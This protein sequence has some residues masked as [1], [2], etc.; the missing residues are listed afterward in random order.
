M[1]SAVYPP[2]L[3]VGELD[4]T[5][6]AVVIHAFAQVD[7]LGDHCPLLAHSCLSCKCN[8]AISF[9]HATSHASLAL[10]SLNL[11]YLDTPAEDQCLQYW[12]TMGLIIWHLKVGMMQSCFI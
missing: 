4:Y 3:S 1:A 8:L 6:L 7:R 12:D 5:G 2:G 9:G 10:G 11:M